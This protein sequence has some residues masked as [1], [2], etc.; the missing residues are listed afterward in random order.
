MGFNLPFFFFGGGGEGDGTRGEGVLRRGQ[1]RGNMISSLLTSQMYLGGAV[2]INE[3]HGLLWVEK[4]CTFSKEKVC[5]V[6]LTSA[7]LAE[8]T[9]V[10]Q[11]AYAKTLY[12]NLG[13][14]QSTNLTSMTLRTNQDFGKRG[15]HVKM[16]K[17]PRSKSIAFV[18]L[19]SDSVPDR[20]RLELLLFSFCLHKLS[21]PADHLT[22][23]HACCEMLKGEGRWEPSILNRTAELWTAVGD[24]LQLQEQEPA[25][26]R[27]E[28]VGSL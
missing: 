13:T 3:I 16:K 17:A 7:W 20:G 6:H 28:M 21:S 10:T 5:S 1:D 9:A 23:L 26:Y 15:E 22:E 25:V 18:H 4:L 12:P 24:S 19:Q 14:D 2:E 8:V 11:K 27:K